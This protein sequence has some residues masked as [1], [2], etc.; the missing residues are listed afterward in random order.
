MVLSNPQKFIGAKSFAAHFAT[1]PVAK[2]VGIKKAVNE[3]DVFVVVS[4]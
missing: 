3:V 2:K 1:I 4:M